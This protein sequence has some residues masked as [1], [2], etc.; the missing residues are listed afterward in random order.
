M[1]VL[2]TTTNRTETIKIDLPVIPDYGSFI[3]LSESDYDKLYKFRKNKPL[4]NFAGIKIDKKDKDLFNNFILDNATVQAV[5]FMWDK[6][7]KAYLPLIL[8]SLDPDFFKESPFDDDDDDDDDDFDEEEIITPMK[9]RVRKK[10]M[11][12]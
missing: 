9:T 3:F 5:D 6:E 12:N 8:L 1:K 4:P 11:F 2:L 7:E 10:N